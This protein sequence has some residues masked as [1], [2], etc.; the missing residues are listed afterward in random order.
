MQISDKK[1]HL[2]A[3]TDGFDFLGWHSKVQN[4]GKFRCVPSVDNWRSFR[5]KVKAIVNSSNYG[6]TTKAE[7]LAPVVRGWRN[8]HRYCRMDGQ[9]H[10]LYSIQK[11]AFTVFNKEVKP[12]VRTIFDRKAIRWCFRDVAGCVGCAAR[13]P[14]CRIQQHV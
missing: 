13:L 1:T 3:T 2:T 7:K 8:Y 4:N 9:R 12:M 14:F 11:R 10:S 6:A 5:K